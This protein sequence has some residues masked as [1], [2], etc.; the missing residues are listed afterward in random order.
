M[1]PDAK[2]SNILIIIKTLTGEN[3][4]ASPE[5]PKILS[6]DTQY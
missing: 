5:P 3:P 4:A 1:S 6:F 2:T